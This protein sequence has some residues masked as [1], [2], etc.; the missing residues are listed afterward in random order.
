MNQGHQLSHLFSH[1]SKITFFVLNQWNAAK[2]SK[3]TG[4]ING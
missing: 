4:F 2:M 3:L 1:A